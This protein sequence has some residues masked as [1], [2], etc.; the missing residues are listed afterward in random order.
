MGLIMIVHAS[1]FYGNANKDAITHLQQFLELL[2][3]FV[4]KGVL[5]DAIQLRLFPFSLLRRAKQWFYANKSAVNTWDN[6]TKAFLAK[7]FPTN[8]TNALRGR[9]SSFQQV[10]NDTI[11]EAWE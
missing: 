11:P 2:T 9:I 5:Q 6:C 3:T 1:P 8:K 10:S 4:I 7:S